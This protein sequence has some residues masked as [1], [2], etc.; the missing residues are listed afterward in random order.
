MLNLYAY[1]LCLCDVFHY[2]SPTVLLM[3]N[4]NFSGAI[5]GNFLWH[6]TGHGKFLL[7]IPI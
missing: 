2:D 6:S 3:K 1:F 5:M 4:M 7:Y